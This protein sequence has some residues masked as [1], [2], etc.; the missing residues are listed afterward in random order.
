MSHRRAP[1]AV[2]P[3]PAPANTPTR[4]PP[5]WSSRRAAY[6]PARPPTVPLRQS[7]CQSLHH[8]SEKARELWPC[9]HECR[10]GEGAEYPLRARRNT[11]RRGTRRRRHPDGCAGEEAD[12][13]AARSKH[14]S[15]RDINRVRMLVTGD[16]RILQH[17]ACRDRHLI[18]Q[19]NAGRRV[20]RCALAAD[21]LQMKSHRAAE[22]T[23]ALWRWTSDCWPVTDMVSGESGER[24]PC[25]STL[26]NAQERRGS[27]QRLSEARKPTAQSQAQA[28]SENFVARTFDRIAA[29]RGSPR[30]GPNQND[31]RFHSAQKRAGEKASPSPPC[32]STP[33]RARSP[34]PASR[35]VRSMATLIVAGGQ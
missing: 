7:N 22:R 25:R 11:D 27:A 20:S 24:R 17:I 8:A 1:A 33:G 18:L 21:E 6:P 29:N 5:C 4:R 9:R 28:H 14:H 12:D 10:A 34:S 35:N 31:R 3:T 30:R 13:R 23:R 26:R 19:A 16:G 2:E 15:H 32:R